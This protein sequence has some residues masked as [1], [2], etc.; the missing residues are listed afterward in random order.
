MCVRKETGKDAVDGVGHPVKKVPP[1]RPPA[2]TRSL[3]PTPSTEP[4]L[5]AE[6]REDDE[7]DG[8]EG[9]YLASGSERILYL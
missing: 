4:L 3:A 1:P 5:A 2:P 8:E 9:T 7:Q 6:D